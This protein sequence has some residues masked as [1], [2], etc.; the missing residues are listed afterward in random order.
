MPR[1][2][3]P[4]TDAEVEKASEASERR[5]RRSGCEAGAHTGGRKL[6]GGK[7]EIGRNGSATSTVMVE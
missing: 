3:T 5:E 4:A 1:G 7:R 2:A 6:E